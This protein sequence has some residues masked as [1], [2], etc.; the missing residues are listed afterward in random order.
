MPDNNHLIG[1]VMSLRENINAMSESLEE[2]KKML[3]SGFP[4]D[5]LDGHK[6]WHQNSNEWQELRAQLVRA[7]L[8][9]AA[10]SIG[11]ASFG[12]ICYAVWTAFKYGVT[13]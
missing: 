4:N 13:H 3:L 7:A 12:W 9:K 2:L 6:R 5:D 1:E 11:I 10:Q 8:I